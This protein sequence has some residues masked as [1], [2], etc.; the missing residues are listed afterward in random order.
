MKSYEINK[1]EAE[2]KLKNQKKENALD[3]M[4]KSFLK[5]ARMVRVV[6]INL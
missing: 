3:I 6:N 5:P 1:S 2:I 4:S